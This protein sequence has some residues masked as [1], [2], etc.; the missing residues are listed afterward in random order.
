MTFKGKL[1]TTD[2][3]FKDLSIIRFDLSQ[4][5]F[6]ILIIYKNIKIKDLNIADKVPVEI[7]A[8]RHVHNHAQPLIRFQYS[9]LP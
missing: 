8:M 1:D 2:L 6:V 7:I 9:V 3:V 4:K 5:Y